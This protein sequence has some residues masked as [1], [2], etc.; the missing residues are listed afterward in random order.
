M[1]GGGGVC[2]GMWVENVEMEWGCEWG[3]ELMVGEV[4]GEVVV[5]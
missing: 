1:G 4:V 3:G 5:G 2:G